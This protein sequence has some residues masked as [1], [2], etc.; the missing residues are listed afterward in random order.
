MRN[1]CK[2]SIIFDLGNVVLFF[3]HGII[4]NK[5]SKLYN[6]KPE[7]VYNKIFTC[8]IEKQFNEGILSP[9]EFTKKCSNVLNVNLN[10]QTFQELWSDIFWK[11]NSVI[12]TIKKLRKRSKLV[13]LSNT[14]I[15]HFEHVNKFYGILE[16]F[17]EFILSYR[18]GISKPNVKI[19]ELAIEKLSCNDKILFIDDI[20]E[21]V[22]AAKKVGL[23]ATQYKNPKLLEKFLISNGIFF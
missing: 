14:N 21:N 6:L 5:L 19:F 16:L 7:F 10:I 3:D 8:K 15:W 13:L 4:C 2:C 17:D 11:N 1:D 9:K 18:F 12:K 22:N 20:E 23:V